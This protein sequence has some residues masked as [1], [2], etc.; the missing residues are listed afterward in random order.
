MARRLTVPAFVAQK[1]SRRLVCLTAYDVLTA[2]ILDEAGVDLILVGDSLGNV[3]LGHETTLP[4]TLDQMISHAAAV[5]RARPKALVI[6]DMPFLT[7]QIS[8]EDTLRNAGRLIQ[9]AGVDGV[10]LEGSRPEHVRMLVGAGIPVMGHL[11]LTPQSVLELGGYRVQGRTPDAAEVLVTQAQA[12]EAAGCFSV[13]LESIP[14]PV[15]ERVTRAIGIPTIGIGAGHVT[16]G[17]IL[18][19]TDLLGMSAATPRF[20]RRYAD[21]RDTIRN[22]VRTYAEDVRG[23][24]FPGPEET[25]PE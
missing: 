20:V 25:Y 9:E 11:G 6:A 18:V 16:D 7:F 13:V 19:V 15:A 2:G 1:G 22:A 10:K 21:L 8:P 3:V 5:M 12:L 24:R 4:V 23:E 17:Q 14:A